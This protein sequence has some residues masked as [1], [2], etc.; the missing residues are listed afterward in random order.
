MFLLRLSAAEAARPGAPAAGRQVTLLRAVESAPDGFVVTDED[1]VIITANAAFLEMAQLAPRAGRGRAAGPLDRRRP[2]WTSIVLIANL[3]QRGAVRFFSPPCA[4]STA[5]P[6]RSRSPPSPSAASGR[7]S[8]GYAI[9]N[10]G[11]RLNLGLQAPAASQAP[12]PAPPPAPA[13]PCPARSS[14]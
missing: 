12:R 13:S 11:P 1:G 3:R 6:R 10:V 9:R 7:L 5:A 14:N 4:A 8:F 2:A